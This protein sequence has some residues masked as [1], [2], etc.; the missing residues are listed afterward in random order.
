MEF[1][2]ASRPEI[3]KELAERAALTKET[4]DYTFNVLSQIIEEKLR[5]G[6]EVLIPYVGR[7]H[8]MEKA[9]GKSNLD[10]S[11]IPPHR[12]LKFRFNRNLARSIRVRSRIY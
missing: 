10:G 7:F 1:G 8:F 4:A 12:Q 2:K 6:K 9:G 3:I 11:V 5:D